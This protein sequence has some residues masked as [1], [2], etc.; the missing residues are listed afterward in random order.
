[1]SKKKHNSSKHLW[2]K[3]LRS[4]RL[5]FRFQFFAYWHYELD[6]VFKFFFIERFKIG[7]LKFELILIYGFVCKIPVLRD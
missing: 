3:G 1:M 6:G 7:T 5:E 4:Q 2:G